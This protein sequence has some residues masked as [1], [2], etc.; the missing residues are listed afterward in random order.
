MFGFTVCWII[1]AC[2]TGNAGWLKFITSWRH[3]TSSSCELIMS[4]FTGLFNT[5]LSWSFF[6]P[7]AKLSYVGY[8]VHPILCY[9][10]FYASP[11]QVYYTNYHFVRL[12]STI[13][14]L[15][16]F[17]DNNYK[18]QV[19][20]FLGH[21]SLTMFLSLVLSSVFEVPLLTIEKYIFPKR[22]WRHLIW[23]TLT[24]WQATLFI[25]LF[26]NFN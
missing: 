14:V 5:V 25:Y 17:S 4:S 8:L 7:L 12:L 13:Q 26:N 20:L 19:Y 3:D 23:M 16:L 9:L 24:P 18:L 6:V 2:I 11:V 15:I 22:K 10:Y 21:L 1:L